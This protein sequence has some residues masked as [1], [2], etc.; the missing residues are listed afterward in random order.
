MRK[1]AVWLVVS[2]LMVLSL[3]LASCAPAA[4][5][6][7]RKIVVREEKEEE[8]KEEKEEAVTKE[9]VKGPKY[10]GVLKVPAYSEVG[11][12]DPYDGF[13]NSFYAMSFVY[14]RL[15]FLSDPNGVATR[16]SQQ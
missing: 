11:T 5:E 9:E 1:K 7:E 6:E 4:T 16:Y 12:W 8:V 15:L 3:V 10:G 13:H 2:C 14:E